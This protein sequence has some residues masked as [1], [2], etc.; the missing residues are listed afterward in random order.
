VKT[1]TTT[2]FHWNTAATESPHTKSHEPLQHKEPDTRST[3]A[4]ALGTAHASD[5]PNWNRHSVVT[6]CIFPQRAV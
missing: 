1:E 3:R 5:M 4:T 6:A 2:V